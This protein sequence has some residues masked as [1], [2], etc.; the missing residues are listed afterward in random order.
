MNK[1]DGNTPEKKTTVMIPEGI[2]QKIEERVNDLITDKDYAL[3]DIRLGRKLMTIGA[4]FGYQLALTSSPAQDI[5]SGELNEQ[6]IKSYKSLAKIYNITEGS[7]RDIFCSGAEWALSLSKPSPAQELFRWVKASE[8][9]PDELGKT[10]WRGV[11]TKEP[12]G[13]G[14]AHSIINLKERRI[15]LETIEW[16]EKIPVTPSPCI[17]TR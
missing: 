8:R 7:V 6:R 12:I 3:V 4:E 14:V 11:T 15:L 13:V 16:L 10:H 2:K 1:I 5:Y 9:L 17:P